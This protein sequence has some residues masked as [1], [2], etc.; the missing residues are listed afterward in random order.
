MM[1][2]STHTRAECTDAKEGRGFCDRPADH[3]TGDAG[4]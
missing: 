4:E 1:P 2:F 3:V